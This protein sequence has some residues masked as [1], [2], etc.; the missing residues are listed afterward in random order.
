ME[1]GIFFKFLTSKSNKLYPEEQF[2]WP[3]G[4]G[5]SIFLNEVSVP[6]NRRGLYFIIL[7]AAGG[8]SICWWM[9]QPTPDFGSSEVNLTFIGTVPPFGVHFIGSRRGTD[10]LLIFSNIEASDTMDLVN[11][12]YMIP[13][14]LNMM[15]LNHGTR[16]QILLY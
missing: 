14:D 6:D 4:T 16:P 11:S 1:Y 5:N 8:F 7:A 2:S 15:N 9:F 13:P 3:Q 10:M 12:Y